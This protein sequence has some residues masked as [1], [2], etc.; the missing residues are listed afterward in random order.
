MIPTL[1]P[2]PFVIKKMYGETVMLDPVKTVATAA[3]R[4]NGPARPSEMS[5]W[6]RKFGY[7]IPSWNT[8]VEYETARM[9]PSGVSAHFSRIEH[10]EDYAAPLVEMSETF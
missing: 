3:D 1:R 9:L 6:T 2:I 10:T 4:G 7:V 5:Q 8:V